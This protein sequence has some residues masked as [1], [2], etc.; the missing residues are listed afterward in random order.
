MKDVKPYIDRSRFVFTAGYLSILEAMVRK[1][2]VFAVY[3]NPLKEDYLKM[4]PLADK[5][6]ITG[7][8]NE[9]LRKVNYYLQH[10]EK[11]K[12][13]VEKAYQW[14]KKQTWSQVADLYEKLWQK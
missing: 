9:L 4:S 2:L 11:E 14:A 10:P 1:R 7:S 6:V 13:L 5:I 8:A 3:D 12:A